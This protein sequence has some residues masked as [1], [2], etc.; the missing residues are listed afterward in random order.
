M[1]LSKE[2]I[3]FSFLPIKWRYALFIIFILGLIF[4]I[5]IV[6]R[7]I[8][9][10]DKLFVP[11]DTYYT[12]AISRSLAFG[13]AP[14]VD[15]NTPTNG[16]QPLLAFLLVPVF[17]FTNS[18][19]I[20]LRVSMV[21][22]AIFDSLTILLISKLASRFL[23]NSPEKVALAAGVL[24]AFSPVAIANALGGLETALA[25]TC[26][27]LLVELWCRAREKGK[28]I[29]FIFI[30]IFAGLSLLARID[31]AF[32]IF[33][34][35]T[36]EILFGYRW[37]ILIG[38]FVALLLVLPWWIYELV[39]FGSIIPESGMA[40]QALTVYHKSISTYIT[41]PKQI[42]WAFGTLIG[43]PFVDLASARQWFFFH[44]TIG[45][46]ACISLTFLL[47]AI[48]FRAIKKK[49][50]D[51][52]I[53]LF[54]LAIVGMVWFYILNV[55]AL[56]FFRRYFA[57]MF[58]VMV[59]LYSWGI[60]ELEIKYQGLRDKKI[61]RTV[62]FIL[63]A[64][65]AVGLFLSSNYLTVQTVTSIDCGMHGAKGFRDPALQIL[66]LA[67]R[68]AVIGALQSGA[69]SYYA[70]TV[71]KNIRVVN[72]DGVVDGNAAKAF[73][74]YRLADYAYQRGVTHFA[75][76]P[77]NYNAFIQRSRKN[78]IISRM[79][80]VGVAERQSPPDAAIDDCMILFKISWL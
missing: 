33:T 20:P 12:L 72:L 45:S 49:R 68:N 11:D 38:G 42:G 28:I 57:P 75:D 62:Y 2:N 8:T 78:N 34:L 1:F 51:V 10:L 26:S 40:V 39:R 71:D 14:T 73:R 66:A 15:G 50:T 7:D 13:L 22:M 41:L 63:Y 30:G 23:K 19:D 44:Y 76:W 37:G 18:P 24:W 64:A 80:Q 9:T 65:A 27:L 67:P 47:I 43:P 61:I 79:E 59:L 74:D 60:A 35:G 52:P 29:S 21:L 6:T 48:L 56:W 32:I 5:S 58:A 77:F 69:L 70:Q 55:P 31:T 54:M 3:M 16:F 17:M 4:R 36:Y 46:F 25:V 53:L